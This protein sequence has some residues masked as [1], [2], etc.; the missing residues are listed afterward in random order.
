MFK[1]FKPLE[2]PYILPVPSRKYITDAQRWCEKIQVYAEHTPFEWYNNQH[3]FIQLIQK[4]D[5]EFILSDA[6]EYFS[7]VTR[8]VESVASSLGFVTEDRIG[9]PRDMQLT[10]PGCFDLVLVH[11]TFV[12]EDEAT[13]APITCL[14]HP[15]THIDFRSPTGKWE[16]SHAAYYSI[17]SINIYLLMYQWREYRQ[18]AAADQGLVSYVH[19]LNR[20]LT[21]TVSTIADLSLLNRIERL[22]QFENLDRSTGNP[23]PFFVKSELQ[24]VR[25]VP[26]N[27]VSLRE[28]LSTLPALHPGGMVGALALPETPIRRHLILLYGLARVNHFNPLRILN[29]GVWPGADSNTVNYF[30]DR[31]MRW[32]FNAGEGLLD[33]NRMRKAL[34]QFDQLNR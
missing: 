32:R 21:Q 29:Q 34:K 23:Y 26:Q 33:T 20:V 2:E 17:W 6:E 12:Y 11:D 27:Y 28:I 14:Y 16:D 7:E 5:N 22:G 24:R 18:S 13:Q 4:L 15:F 31:F 10:S 3:R 19:F 1:L 30:V 9:M 25:M 8:R